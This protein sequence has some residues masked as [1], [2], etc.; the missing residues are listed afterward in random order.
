[1]TWYLDDRGFDDSTDAGLYASSVFWEDGVLDDR[2]KLDLLRGLM[3]FMDRHYTTSSFIAGAPAMD[4]ETPSDVVDACFIG[5]I[6]CE[7]DRCIREGIT[8]FGPFTWRDD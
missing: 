2:T 1:M 5:Y 6:A 8:V 3:G 7:L 4:F